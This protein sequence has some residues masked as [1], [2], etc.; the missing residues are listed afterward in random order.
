MRSYENTKKKF[1][2]DVL[3]Q[4][5]YC[6]I[7]LTRRDFSARRYVSRPGGRCKSGIGRRAVRYHVNRSV[8]VPAKIWD[9]PENEP[10]NLARKDQPL[11][12][13]NSGPAET[14]RASRGRPAP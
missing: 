8:P 10:S 5:S 11:G 3:Y 13:R 2:N 6:G 12:R 4:L 7:D 14:R 9:W 1:T